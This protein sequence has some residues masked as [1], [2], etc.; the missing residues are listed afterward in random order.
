MT[1]EETLKGIEVLRATGDESLLNLADRLEEEEEVRYSKEQRRGFASENLTEITNTVASKLNG[2]AWIRGC[3]Y[4]VYISGAFYI[5]ITDTMREWASFNDMVCAYN[6][7]AM[8]IVVK[9]TT[10]S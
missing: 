2:K 7:L 9:D 1:R 3:N 8:N 4:R 10:R 5:D 6:N